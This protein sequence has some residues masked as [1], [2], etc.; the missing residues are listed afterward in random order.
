MLGFNY[1]YHPAVKPYFDKWWK[2]SDELLEQGDNASINLHNKENE[3]YCEAK[4]KDREISERLQ[5]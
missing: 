5:K 2:I 4:K 3:A 1:P